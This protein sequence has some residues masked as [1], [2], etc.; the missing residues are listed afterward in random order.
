[1]STFDAAIESVLA[2][3]GGL[4][5]DWRDHGGTTKFGISKAAFPFEDIENLTIERAK[6]LY[7]Q[8]YWGAAW[9]TID[10]QPLATY[11]LDTAINMGRNTAERLCQQACNLAGG[12]VVVDC[13]V[14][15]KTIAE[16]NRIEAAMPGLVLKE[17][18]GQ[19]VL[20]YVDII[21]NAPTQRVFALGWIRRALA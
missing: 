8:H 6:W 16:L 21:L 18:R 12:N 20:R 13:L 3:E 17:F 1:M 7:Q 2:Q 19:R 9:D 10:S 4:S 14:G 15:A 5:T 11:L